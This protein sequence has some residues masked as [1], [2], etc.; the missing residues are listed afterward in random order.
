MGS[1]A[2]GNE[3]GP[4][5]NRFWSNLELNETRVNPLGRQL[6]CG[7]VRQFRPEQCFFDEAQPTNE[8]AKGNPGFLSLDCCGFLLQRGLV[9]GDR[10]NRSIADASLS[11]LG[12]EVV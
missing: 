11:D 3:L 8:D 10:Q 5:L 6:A 9:R 7:R 2:A 4:L 1:I 12:D